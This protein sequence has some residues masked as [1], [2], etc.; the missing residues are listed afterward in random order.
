MAT[1]ICH[2]CQC[3][4]SLIP[5]SSLFF[6]ESGASSSISSDESELGTNSNEDAADGA[7]T[8]I[9]S[10]FLIHQDLTSLSGLGPVA[11]TAG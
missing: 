7:L 6:R 8:S 2:L 4:Y 11:L 10:V 3:N 1:N 5:A 9:G